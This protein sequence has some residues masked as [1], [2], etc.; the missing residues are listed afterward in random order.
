MF[1]ESGR[2]CNS[3]SQSFATGTFDLNEI[4]SFG[5]FYCLNSSTNQPTESTAGVML[6][7]KGS[8]SLQVQIFF[9]Y[10]ENAIYK[11][12]RSSSSWG[13]WVKLV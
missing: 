12:K 8:T 2:S 6:S 13:E 10:T 7:F 5:M 4:T 9:P 3:I 1:G 11:R